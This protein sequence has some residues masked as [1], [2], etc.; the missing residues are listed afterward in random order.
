MAITNDSKISSSLVDDTRVNISETWDSIPTTWASETRTWDDT[1]S[2]IGNTIREVDPIYFVSA[3]GDRYFV[4]ALEDRYL[5][6][7][8]YE[9][10]GMVNTSKT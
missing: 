8:A 2:L 6:A 5:A 10:T 7:I 1:T 4:G 3:S 9:G